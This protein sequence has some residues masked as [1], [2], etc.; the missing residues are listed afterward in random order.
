M[1]FARSLS[2]LDE[3]VPASFV[4]VFPLLEDIAAVVAV[5]S[6]LHIHTY[7]KASIAYHFLKSDRNR[8]RDMFAF[9]LT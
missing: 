5:C 4:C 8:S 9:V 7:A 6:E 2:L 1:L 3:E